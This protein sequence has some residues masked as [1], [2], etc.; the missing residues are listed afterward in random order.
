MAVKTSAVN[1]TVFSDVA[2]C[3]LV[4]VDRRFRGAYSFHNQG[5]QNSSETSV[6]YAVQYPRRLSS[7][8]S[9]VRTSNL[10]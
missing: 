8:Y 6:S 3:S 2:P 1:I 4:E 10:T 5:D 7:S 9:A